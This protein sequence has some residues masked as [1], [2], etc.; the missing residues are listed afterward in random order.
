ML[1]TPRLVLRRWVEE[2]RVPFAAMNA[3]PAVMEYL[4]KVLDRAESDAMFD[5]IVETNLLVAEAKPGGAFVGFIGLSQPRFTAHFTPCTE[6][7]WRLV[8]SAWGHGYATEGARAALAYG[9]DA[10]G[11]DEIVSFTVPANVRSRRVMEKLGM[12]RSPHEDFDHP[13]LAEGH[14]LR[15]HVLYRLGRSAFHRG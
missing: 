5:R 11:L 10:L 12:T 3:D 13:A 14:P 15:R 8:R 2:D 7:A 4:P 1:E 6:V 9:F